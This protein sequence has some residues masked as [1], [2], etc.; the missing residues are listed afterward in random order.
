MFEET[1]RKLKELNG[2]KATLELPLD[3]NGYF[4]RLCPSVDCQSQ[5]KILFEDWRDTIRD[6]QVFCPSCRHEASSTEW[7]TAQQAEYIKG[8][9]TAFVLSELE[10]AITTDAQRQNS[11]P[12]S[13]LSI[14]ISH[15]KDQIP[16]PV[17]IDA[18]DVMTQEARCSECGC[19]YTSIG[20]VFFCPSCGNNSVLL[21]FENALLTVERTLDS[22]D[23][24]SSTLAIAHD[25]NIALDACKQIIENCLIK[26]VASF[27]RFSE[28]RFF[29]LPNSSSFNPRRNLFQN[30][31]KSDAIWREANGSGYTDQISQTEY[32]MMQDFFQQ[33][34]LLAHQDGIVDQ[35]YK[36]IVPTSRYQIG[37]KLSIRPE[38]VREFIVIIRKLAVCLQ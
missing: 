14:T 28:A 20:S 13:F 15:R 22:I 10:E 29:A 37:Q 2:Q 32:A 21:S 7:N 26:L 23:A 16:I 36:E 1:M 8:V 4:D 19:R 31:N 38:A 27:Q 17:P 3:A 9:G 6:E 34:H 35:R 12:N 11:K 5:F 18:T 25:E 24:I 33:R 30:L